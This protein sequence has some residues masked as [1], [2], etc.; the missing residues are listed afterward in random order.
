ME[1]PAREASDHRGIRSRPAA[2]LPATPWRT[3]RP[4]A[5]QNIPAEV[6]ILDDLGQLLAH[7]GRVHLH[8]LLLQVRSLE[9]NLF[10]Q[11]FENGMQPPRPDILRIF[12]HAR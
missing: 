1:Y 3:R 4:R 5:S 12:V 8:G 10:Q 7:V 11:L 2:P 9:G 6:L